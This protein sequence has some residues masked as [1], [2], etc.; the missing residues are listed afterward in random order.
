[1]PGKSKPK[2]KAVVERQELI[3]MPNGGLDQVGV[4]KDAAKVIANIQAQVGNQID[5]GHT[6]RAFEYLRY[7]NGVGRISG[8]GQAAALWKIKERWK[9]NGRDGVADPDIT[10]DEFAE[11]V[12]TKVGYAQDTVKRYITAW[13]FMN[14][15]YGRVKLETWD[16]LV[17]RNITDLIAIGQYVKEHGKLSVAEI[18]K[19]SLTPDL[20]TL[21]DGLRKQAG[22][23][24]EKHPLGIRWMPD[25]SLEA[26][27]NDE[28]Q[29]IGMLIR[30]EAG[31]PQSVGSKALARLVRRGGIH[32]QN[33]A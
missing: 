23:E 29:I 24:K 13:D 15:A 27:S 21:R 1:M 25:G 5:E 11:L 32:D 8:T 6:D 19:L 3:P 17:N 14:E 4:I 9:P 28:V 12:W 20:A 26:W 10:N 2:V 31:K 22:D 7:L 18:N 30:P 16:R 33:A